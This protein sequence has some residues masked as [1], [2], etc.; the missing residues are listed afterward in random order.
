MP[1]KADAKA[2][3]IRPDL[4]DKVAIK[5]ATQLR[6]HE[7]CNVL[8]LQSARFELL[9]CAM[10]CDRQ[11]GAPLPRWLRIRAFAATEFCELRQQL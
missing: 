2:A 10:T 8:A 4:F 6:Q 11:F 1:E 9:S 7:R 5:E 3:P